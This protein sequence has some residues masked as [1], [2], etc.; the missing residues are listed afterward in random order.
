MNQIEYKSNLGVSLEECGE[1]PSDSRN[2]MKLLGLKRH[3]R[4][5][6]MDPWDGMD[7]NCDL[8]PFIGVT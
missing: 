5:A 2:L 8:T 4:K 3:T 6:G 1:I 7:S